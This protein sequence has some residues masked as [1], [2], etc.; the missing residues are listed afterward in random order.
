MCNVVRRWWEVGQH[1]RILPQHQET[2]SRWEGDQAGGNLSVGRQDGEAGAG[3]ISA[4]RSQY[5]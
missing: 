4:L 2:P 3:A 1:L 5:L